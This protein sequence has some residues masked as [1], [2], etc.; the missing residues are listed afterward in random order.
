MLWSCSLGVQ[1]ASHPLPLI[2]EVADRDRIRV[3]L[4]QT[5][6]HLF[7]EWPDP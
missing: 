5:L 2:N 7:N 1:K 3:E 6:K 4:A